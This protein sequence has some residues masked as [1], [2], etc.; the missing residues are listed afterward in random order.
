MRLAY[1]FCLSAFTMLC[2]LRA[3]DPACPAY[4]ASVRTEIESSIDLDRQAAEFSRLARKIRAG[5]PAMTTRLAASSNFVDQLVNKKMSA[6]GVVPAPQTTDAEF[7]RRVYLDLTGR[8]PSPEQAAGFLASESSAK[9]ADL[10]DSLLS[11]KAYADQLT[12]F[13]AN[14][15]RVT[16]SHDNIST[17]ARNVFN[18]FLHDLFANDQPYD[19]FVRKLITASG[20]VDSSPG[21]QFFARWMDLNGPIQDSWD[22]TTEK[23]TTSFLGYKTECISCH[24]GRGHLEKINLHLSQRTRKDL[25]Q[26]SAFLSRMNFLRLS[27]DPIGYRPRVI[28]VDRSY[29]TYSGAVPQSNP[30]CRPAR[31]D[32]VVTPKFFSSGKEPASGAWRQELA[33]MITS[34]RQFARAAANYIWSYLFGYGIVDPPDAWDLARVDPANPPAGEWA[35]QNS[36][37]ELLEKLA[38]YLIENR[39]RLKPLIRQI[40]TSDT[41]QL[42]S[43]YEGKWQPAFV[44]YFARYQAR[45]L[46][47]EQMYDT[48]VTATHTEQP[49]A[50][51]GGNNVVTYANQLPDPTEPFSDSRVLDFM[52]QFGRGN[53][54][55][56]DRTSTPTIL[57]LL[58]MMNDSNNVYRSM[59]TSSAS[60]GITNRVHQVNAD[61]ADD[62]EAIRQIFLATLTRY[63]S[64][65]ELSLVMTRRAGPRYQWLSDLQWALLNKLDFAFNY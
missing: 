25:W 53:W 1:R 22:D 24:N 15:Y 35:M 33:T 7:L 26:M 57:G 9:R 37:P 63:P 36:N 10:V 49:M 19:D 43:R 23:I 52:T 45:R 30:G 39:Y 16:R 47:A 55:T 18:N 3:Q 5:R 61:H 50:I 4:P 48:L 14:R 41:Y 6:D 32:A 60:V 54:W 59:G 13:L 40:V 27:D 38:D 20:E 62:T 29:G 12:L 51:V 8:I 31:L 2:A 64:D 11:S 17:P 42:S 58:F 44:R 65:S 56:I 21:T 28:V 46:S 34:D